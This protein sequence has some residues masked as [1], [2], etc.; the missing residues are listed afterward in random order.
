MQ[1]QIE[2]NKFDLEALQKQGSAGIRNTIMTAI[3]I[4]VA[5]IVI[6]TTAPEAF[7][8]VGNMSTEDA[9]TFFTVLFPL[10]V[11]AV[12]LFVIIQWLRG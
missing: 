4:V 8:A 3:G 6:A 7:T 1:T 2:K 12:F 5:V 9:P 10:V 11:G